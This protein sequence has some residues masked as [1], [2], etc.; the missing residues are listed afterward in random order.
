MTDHTHR[1]TAAFALSLL[2]LTNL[3][4]DCTD[5]Q[6]VTLCA[7]A[8]TPFGHSAAICIWP[9]FVTRARS[10]LGTNHAVKIATVV[11]FPAG[12]MEV[13]DVAAETR[14]AIAD[15]ADEID[16]VIPYRKLI[17][18]DEPAVTEMVAAI[19]AECASPI[20][21]KV[22]L[23]T[24]ELKDTGLIRRAGEL[25]IAAGA[26]FI[27]TSTGKVAVN[28]TLETAD[29]ML[30]TIRDSG[31]KVGFKP[32]G[33]IGSVAEA[34][35]YLRL[36]ETIMAPDWAM[37][38]TFRFGASGLLDDILSVLSGGPPITLAAGY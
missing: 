13:A 15:G 28:A 30:R 11:N 27:K 3:K 5:T 26:D 2:D 36:A 6:I 14:E 17:A 31:R 7:R 12:D 23:E 1:E 19:R 33:G 4:D 10:I 21:L 34:A 20:L 22:I 25:A 24:G 16:L 32:A 8:Q 18:G 38:S 35:L 9:R 29:V 37:P